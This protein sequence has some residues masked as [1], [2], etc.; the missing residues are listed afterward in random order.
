MMPKSTVHDWQM[1]FQRKRW[2]ELVN[3][4]RRLHIIHRLP[5]ET[6]AGVIEVRQREGWYSEA[7]EAYLKAH[8]VQVSQVLSDHGP[9]FY[10]D[11]GKNRFTLYLESHRIRTFEPKGV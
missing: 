7:I 4:S 2:A 8:G 9:Q 3:E 6:V 11:N 10:S 5:Q 1:R